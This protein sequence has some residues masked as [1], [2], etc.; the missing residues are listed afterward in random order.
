MPELLTY[1]ANNYKFWKEMDDLG[2]TTFK[3]L[4]ATSQM[5]AILAGEE[6]SIVGGLARVSE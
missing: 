6:A 1:L 3:E 2:V 4:K 5:A